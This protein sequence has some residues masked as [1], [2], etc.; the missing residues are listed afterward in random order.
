MLVDT[1]NYYEAEIGRF[2]VPGV[3]TLDPRTRKFSQFPAWVEE[4]KDELVGKQVF[5]YCTGGIRCE[6]AS[7][8]VRAH[9]G[10]ATVFQLSGGIHN[11]V[12]EFGAHGLWRGRNFVFDNR[13]SIAAPAEGRL[14]TP[15]R[16]AGAPCV[17]VC[18]FCLRECDEHQ[19]CAS[20]GCHVYVVACARCR[21][22]GGALHCCE[23]C[24]G[25]DWPQGARVPCAGGPRA[26]VCYCDCYR[27]A[28]RLEP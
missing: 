20:A 17:C 10:G 2:V 18:F 1:R 5:M 12:D 24:R 16:E 8:L 22:G 14:Q 27:I 11:Y 21:D 15:A 13:L 26:G 25:E 19:K 23:L 28:H 7:A 4:H 9:A 6:R 3:P